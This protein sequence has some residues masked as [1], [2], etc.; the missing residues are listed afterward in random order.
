[1]IRSCKY[2]RIIYFDFILHGG[3][4]LF[5]LRFKVASGASTSSTE[6]IVLANQSDRS[7]QK[8]VSVIL[9]A[10]FCIFLLLRYY[11]LNPLLFLTESKRK[12]QDYHRKLYA[13]EC[14]L[15][16]LFI[17]IEYERCSNTVFLFIIGMAR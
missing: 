13:S 16:L 3:S 4:K 15:L 6:T 11:K 5:S 1:M 7:P 14:K 9:L 8:K 17:Y 2:D 12:Q 10:V